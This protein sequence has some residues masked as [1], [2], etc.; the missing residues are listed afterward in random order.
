MLRCFYIKNEGK[1]FEEDFKKSVPNDHC[2]LYRL[3][4]NAASFS[5]GTNV[6]FASS[7]ICDYILFDDTTSTLLLLELK[8]TKGKSLTYWRKD[9]DGKS[10]MIK[11]NQILGLTEANKHN[12]IAGLVIN[13][14]EYDNRTFFIDIDEFNKLTKDL[15]KK[16]I[17]IDDIEKCKHI[18]ISNVQKKI[19][20]L[21]DIEEFLEEIN[22]GNKDE[23]KRSY[24]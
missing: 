4:D 10:F 7:N 1:K 12:L 18:E 8:S 21:Y 11:K 22:G 14:R 16:S 17:N 23:E 9:F 19:R 15:N 20:Y 2:W 6:R 24:N 13:F 3:R 5:G